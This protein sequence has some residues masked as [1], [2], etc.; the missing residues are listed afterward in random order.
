MLLPIQDVA[1]RTGV[2]SRALRHYGDVGILPPTKTDGSGRRFYDEAAL[3]R[4]QRILVMRELG[5]GIPAIRE[6]I[7]AQTADPEALTAHLAQLQRESRRILTLMTAVEQ[8]LDAIQTKGALMVDTMF[9][10]FQH[11]QY[12]S[13]VRERWG[14]QAW[15]DGNDWWSALDADDRQGFLERHRSLQDAYDAAIAQ[16]LT[17]DAPQV[18]LIAARHVEWIAAGWQGRSPD[19]DAVK[20]LAEMYVADARFAKNYT[21][22]HE[23]GAEFVRDALCHYADRSMQS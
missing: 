19:A 20:G 16:R 10:G 15:D 17:A 13:E 9:D 5:M 3:V 7:E 8:T 11:E 1:R 12:E 4:L 18:Q 6:A 14:D 23:Q 2:T 21:R 22:E